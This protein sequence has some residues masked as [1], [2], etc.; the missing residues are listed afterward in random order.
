MTQNLISWP[1]AFYSL[2]KRR[3]ISIISNHSATKKNRV[4]ISLINHKKP[5][6]Q[7]SNIC[8]KHPRLPIHMTPYLIFKPRDIIPSILSPSNG[9]R[10]LVE[11]R[12]LSPF[13]ARL[14]TSSHSLA[15]IKAQRLASASLI[16]PSKDIILS[17]HESMATASFTW[18]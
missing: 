18:F 16:R 11:S 12:K 17:V 4:S 6:D 14:R 15:A 10:G 3:S 5:S 1:H 2:R 8:L 9:A 13:L 7:L